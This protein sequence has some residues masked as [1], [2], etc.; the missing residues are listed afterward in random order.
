VRIFSYLTHQLNKYNVRL[1]I[2]GELTLFPV[3]V[4]KIATEAQTLLAG[5]SGLTLVIAANYGGQ[6]DIVNACKQIIKNKVTVDALNKRKF[7]QYL[8]LK[9]NRVH[10][11]RK[12]C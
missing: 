5:N 6:W 2:I 4:Q 9:N 7:S 12:Q 10:I 8:S 3:D 11:D 1:K